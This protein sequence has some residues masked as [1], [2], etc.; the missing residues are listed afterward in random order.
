MKPFMAAGR[1]VNYLDQDE[2]TDSVAAAYG[3][4]YPRLKELKAKYDPGNWFHLNQNIQ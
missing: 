4:N 3:P 2:G 1:Y